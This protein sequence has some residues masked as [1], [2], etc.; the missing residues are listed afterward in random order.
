MAL[1]VLSRSRVIGFAQQTAWG[2]AVAANGSYEALR[3]DAGS[4][5]IDLDIDVSQN[6]T[7]TTTGVIIERARTITD[8][9][10]GLPKYNFTMPADRQNL[11]VLFNSACHYT[12]EVETTP[13]Q[14]TIRHLGYSEVPD[15]TVVADA[16]DPTLLTIAGY[17]NS[18]TT[19][20]WRLKNAILNTLGFTIDFNARGVARLA[21]VSGQ[22]IGTAITTNES[23]NGATFTDDYTS[24]WYNQSGKFTFGIT[25]PA[26][27][28]DICIKRFS[29][30]INNN[31]FSDCRTTDGE[32]N[33]YKINPELTCEVVIPYNAANYVLFDDIQLGTETTFTL[34]SSITSGTTG[35][36][37]IITKGRLISATPVGDANGYQEMTLQMRLEKP[38]SGDALY[39]VL[40][41]AKERNYRIP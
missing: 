39:I 38:A 33:N 24:Y 6:D 7:T 35:H 9:K 5:Q 15:F 16:T 10:T 13:F 4:G 17:G 32:S 23:L 34:T 3:I 37:Q 25:G 2:T 20:G 30:N 28:S 31:V 18:I 11:A 8:S 21:Q 1:D 26:T 22:F 29:L 19:D 14:K 41:D 27:I 36:L 12:I 40:A